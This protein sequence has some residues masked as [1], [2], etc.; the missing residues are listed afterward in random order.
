MRSC[1]YKSID[2]I[3]KNTP[4]YRDDGLISTSFELPVPFSTRANEGQPRHIIFQKMP[5]DFYADMKKEGV[6]TMQ[7]WDLDE[8]EYLK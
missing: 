3:I 8:S 4:V 1:C 6:T 2:L 7:H 5:F